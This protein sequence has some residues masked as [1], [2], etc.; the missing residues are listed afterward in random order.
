MRSVV[1]EDIGEGGWGREGMRSIA[2][3]NVLRMSVEPLRQSESTGAGHAT[4]LWREFLQQLLK[5]LRAL[6]AWVQSREYVEVG[7]ERFLL[8]WCWVLIAPRS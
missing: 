8:V 1:R 5:L 3:R 6:P 4:H 2:M 7:P